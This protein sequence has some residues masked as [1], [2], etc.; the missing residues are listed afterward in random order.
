MGWISG[1]AVYFI[2]WWTA[3]FLVL[4]WGVKPVDPADVAK[5]HAAGAPVRPQM[6][7]RVAATTVV[8]GL[9]W[10]VVYVIIETGAVSIRPEGM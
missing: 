1:I 10:L 3:L 9:L 5:G 8:A 6:W 7:R 4:P 2:I